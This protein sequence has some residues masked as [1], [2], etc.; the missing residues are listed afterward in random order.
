MLL[1]HD[2]WIT[3]LTKSLF[4]WAMKRLR[5]TRLRTK[6]LVCY[7]KKSGSHKIVVVNLKPLMSVTPNDDVIEGQH[8]L[9]VSI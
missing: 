5:A 7:H 3:D 9:R 1:G 6:M 4:T 8:L 2:L